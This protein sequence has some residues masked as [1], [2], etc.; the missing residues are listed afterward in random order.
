MSRRA[1]TRR[2]IQAA[3]AY[4]VVWLVCFVESVICESAW[5]GPFTVFVSFLLKFVIAVMIAVAFGLLLLIPKVRDLWR[6]VGHRSLLLSAVALAVMVF[7]SKLGL[8]KV[9][10]VS[11]YR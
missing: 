2:F 1:I 3:V 11:N 6:R 9:D 4:A 8:R 5:G 7:A 10:P